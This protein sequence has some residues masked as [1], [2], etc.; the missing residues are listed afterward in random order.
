MS[1]TCLTIVLAAGEGKRM[2]SSLPKVLHKVAGLPM[3]A[4]VLQT[5]RQAGSDKRVVVAGNGAGQ[6]RETIN[7][8]DADTSIVIQAQRLGTAHAVLAARSWLEQGFDDV[9][10]LYGDVPLIREQTL[11]DIRGA[12]AKGA[13]V[14]AVGFETANPDGYGRFVVTG[15]ELIAIREDR[16]ATDEEK[17]IT[18]CNSGIIC[19]QGDQALGLLDAVENS[20]SQS[21]YY[22]TDVVEIARARGGRVVALTVDEEE[23]LGV[24]NRVQLAEAEAIWQRRKRE[25]MM[26]AGVSLSAPETVMFCH[27]TVVGE[28]SVIEPHVVFAAGV[29]IGM[30]ATIRSFSHLEGAM[31][32][33]GA[34]IGPFARLRPGAR[35]SKSAKVGNFCE[36]KNAQIG[37]G[38]KVNHLTYIGDAT[39]GAGTNVGAGT[40]TCNYDGMNKHRTEIGAN[41]FVGTNSSLVAPV[42]VGDGAHI[43]AGSVVTEDVPADA[44][45]IGRGRQ[46]NKP[47]RAAKLREKTLAIKRNR[48]S[49]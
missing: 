9:L 1:R 36:V 46:V 17:N 16:D 15:E 47:G 45:A 6:V 40:V 18:L 4:H 14:V 10:V 7:G 8:I 49:R 37:E 48:D 31:I 21:E 13:D 42:S 35:L 11:A 5:V 2:K 25:E 24:N 12:L 20:N 26:L 22:L 29:E 32:G 39:I 38:A 3:V 41:V 30:N 28:G 33:E 44:L 19:M 27:D 34:V 23:T 43:A